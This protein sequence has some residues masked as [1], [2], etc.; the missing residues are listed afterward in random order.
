VLVQQATNNTNEQFSGSP[1][2]ATIDHVLETGS[3]RASQL[4]NRVSA[5]AGCKHLSGA[6]A[7]FF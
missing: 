3:G 7:G 4:S 2:L 1:G 5:E 6:A